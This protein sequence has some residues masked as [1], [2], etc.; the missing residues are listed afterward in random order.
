MAAFLQREGG[1]LTPFDVPAVVDVG[2]L[3]LT[4]PT[5]V[6]FNAARTYT[7]VGHPRRAR[8]RSFA[9]VYNTDTSTA[10][11]VENVYSTN[12]GATWNALP[13]FN[14]ATQTLYTG[15]PFLMDRTMNFYAELD[16]NVGT[17]YMFGLRF[18]ALP[19]AT[20]VGYYCN[21]QARIF[22]RNGATAPF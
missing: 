5:V 18:S 9:N 16:L 15:R 3:I 13:T 10:V 6:C 17:S 12:G 22:N 2:E 19:A 8:L 1:I 7:V 21:Y 20:S 11:T 14:A 4:M